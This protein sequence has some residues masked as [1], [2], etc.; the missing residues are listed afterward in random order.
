MNNA[1]QEG[2]L[3][4]YPAGVLLVL[5]LTDPV[6]VPDVEVR[7]RLRQF[8]TLIH[9]LVQD[10]RQRAG[11]SRR[12]GE[13]A[14]DMCSVALVERAME[15]ARASPVES[16]EFLCRILDEQIAHLCGTSLMLS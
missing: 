15:D 12:F 13:I 10:R 11:D 8:Q 7:K 3:L 6:Q 9:H 14:T 1:I 2:D 5:C 4:L 16:D